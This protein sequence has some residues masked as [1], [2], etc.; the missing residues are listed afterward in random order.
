MIVVS[1]DVSDDR[2]EAICLKHAEED[3][4][5]Q[6]IK[7]PERL[8]WSKNANAL[9]GSVETDYFFIY[10]HDDIIE[11]AYVEVLVDVLENNPEAASA[12]CDLAEFGLKER[13][14][15]AHT[16]QG[17]A[18]RRLVDFMTTRRGTMLR[19]MVRRK[20][21]NGALRFPDI[22]GDNQWAAFAFHMQLVAAGP[23]IGVNHILYKRWHREGSLTR[24][25]GWMSDSMESVLLGQKEFLACSMALFEGLK[26]ADEQLAVAKQCLAMFQLEFV[27][28]QQIRLNNRE[29]VHLSDVMPL[30][31]ESHSFPCDGLLDEEMLRCIDRL[32]ESLLRLE[33]KLDGEAGPDKPPARRLSNLIRGLFQS[34][35]R[36]M[37]E[38]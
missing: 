18:L 11:P 36:G 19:S 16:Y 32:K 28:T 7:Q 37:G 31:E 24:S 26:L 8:G 15:P 29:D 12:H 4:R 20:A 3:G 34:K 14:R 22:H 38:G 6:V 21:L 17:S 27:R 30:L 1:I 5:V 23:A 9:L 33:S 13:I 10:F 35:S 2:T 25:T